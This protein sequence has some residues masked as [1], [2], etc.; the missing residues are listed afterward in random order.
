V[1]IYNVEPYLNRCVESIINQTYSNLEII[2]VDDGSP[3]CCGKI[4]DDWSKKDC[5]IKVIHKK[6]GGLSDARNAGMKIATGQYLAFVDSDDWIE[7]DFI[8]TLYQII[9]EENADI[10]ACG[11]KYIT[12]DDKVIYIRS[13]KQS[14]LRLSK[15]QALNRLVL[16]DGVFQTVWNKLYKRKLAENL[17][18]E[19][20]KYNEDDF[21]TYQVIEKAEKMIVIDKPLYYYLQRQGSIMGTQYTLKRKDGL[22]ARFKRMHDFQKYKELAYLTREHLYYD[23]LY[24]FQCAI[25]YLKQEEQEILISYILKIMKELP[26]PF[27][28]N[29]ISFKYKIWFALFQKFP[30]LTARIRNLLKIGI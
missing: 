27:Q 8:S 14:K 17:F 12:E 25:R 19:I 24:H 16:E 30:F 29:T 23:C 18:F 1:P 15:I 11:V 22:E 13:C 20:G 4:C 28:C 26:D 7:K 9:Q 21:W 6:N 5:R 2:L 10:A 3:D